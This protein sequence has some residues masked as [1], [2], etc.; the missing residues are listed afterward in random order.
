[1]TITLWKQIATS[2]HR[3]NRRSIEMATSPAIVAFTSLQVKKNKYG[4]VFVSS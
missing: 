3:F 1:M 2:S 4:N